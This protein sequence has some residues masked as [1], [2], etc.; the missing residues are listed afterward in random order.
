[1]R[2][3]Q[4]AQHADDLDRAADFYTALLE[5]PPTALFDPP[6][7]L[8]FDLDGVRLLLDRNAPT[9]LVYLHVHN[10]HEVLERLDGIVDV[11]SRPHVIFRHEDDALGPS[12]H[13]EWQAFIRDSEG[14]TVGLI[15]FQRP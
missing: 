11:V 14:N 7:L 3:V 8:F 4:I 5:T 13:D 10:V 2:L 1:M 6:G 9:S 12:G 15:A